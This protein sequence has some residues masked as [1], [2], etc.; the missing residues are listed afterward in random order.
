[1]PMVCTATAMVRPWIAAAIPNGATASE[2][3]R[4]QCRQLD[5]TMLGRSA[6]K[7]DEITAENRDA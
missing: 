3:K 6:G 2:A 5:G 4:Q 1:M 7:L